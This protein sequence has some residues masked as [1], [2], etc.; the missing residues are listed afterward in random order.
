MNISNLNITLHQLH[1]I[2]HNLYIAI[3]L[4]LLSCT[5]SYTST[6]YADSFDNSV[7]TTDE[8]YTAMSRQ[9][10]AHKTKETYY[11]AAAELQQIISG[12]NGWND[13]LYHYN[14]DNPLLSGCYTSNLAFDGVITWFP[15]NNR[16][17]SITFNYYVPKDTMDAYFEETKALAN[18][19]R[20]ENDFESVKNVHD[21]II[22]RVEYDHSTAG[23]NYTDIEGFRENRMVCLGYSMAT[24]V[25]LSRMNIPCRIVTGD[26]GDEKNHGPHAWNIVMIDSKWYNYDATWDDSEEYGAHYTF[27][28]KSNED[29][30]LHTPQE[31]YADSDFINMISTES[32]NLPFLLKSRDNLWVIAIVVLIIV[33]I[34]DVY[35]IRKKSS[36]SHTVVQYD[37]HDI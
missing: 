34:Y 7:S 10:L 31:Y 26:A 33:V 15:S 6:S 20:G 25:L 2:K 4:I 12:K 24:F 1:I 13:F 35:I 23:E 37:I 27:F 11:L 21:Y 29:F 18:E 5:L 19:L 8:L 3:L 36:G 16:T 9:I 22:D 14:P 32:Y 30:P 28:L 17:I